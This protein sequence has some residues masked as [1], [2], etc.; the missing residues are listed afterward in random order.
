M[1]AHEAAE[2]ECAERGHL[3]ERL[4]E[5]DCARCGERVLEA[6]RVSLEVLRDGRWVASPLPTSTPM[7]CG[8]ARG[9]NPPPSPLDDPRA[10]RAPAVGAD[11]R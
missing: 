5:R 9:L 7:R 10:E 3:V 11:E 6:D 1:R 2:Q 8:V 4:L